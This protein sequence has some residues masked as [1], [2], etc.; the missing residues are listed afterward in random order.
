[1]EV[2]C[3]VCKKIRTSGKWVIRPRSG[4]IA[5][6]TSHGYCPDCAEA[7]SAEIRARRLALQTQIL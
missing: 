4:V 3:C 5:S 6:E 7:A 1:M 2:Q